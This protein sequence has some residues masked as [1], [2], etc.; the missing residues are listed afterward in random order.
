MKNKNTNK[1]RSIEAIS[2]QKFHSVSFHHKCEPRGG[3]HNE[4]RDLLV[5][6]ND[7]DVY[8]YISS[9]QQQDEE[10]EKGS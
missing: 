4:F 9:D 10:I 3:S 8:D 2:L 5:E 1:Q 7:D 6:N